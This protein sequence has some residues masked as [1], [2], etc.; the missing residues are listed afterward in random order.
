VINVSYQVYATLERRLPSMNV[1]VPEI[2]NRIIKA[3][4]NPIPVT[5]FRIHQKISTHPKK[6]T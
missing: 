4:E 2:S 6:Q 1:K 5:K 3:M